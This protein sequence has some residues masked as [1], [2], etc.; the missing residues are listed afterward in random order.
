[1]VRWILLKLVGIFLPSLISK[2]VQPSQ[3]AATNN[4]VDVDF[5]ILDNELGDKIP[6]PKFST[7]GSAALD[8][9]TNIREKKVLQSDET[10][11][12]TTGFSIHIKDSKFAALILPRS[13]LGHK[14]GI[15]LGNLVGLIDSDYQGPLMVSCWNRSDA[16]FTIE[17]YDRIAQLVFI[18]VNQ[19]EFKIVKEFKTCFQKLFI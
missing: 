7:A 2:A 17:P 12:F 19:P 8:L 15:V 3:K 4:S 13:G 14:H 5:K 18:N 16:H 9:R 11:L 1:M 10:Y 6:L